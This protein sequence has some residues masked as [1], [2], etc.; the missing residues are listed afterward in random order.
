MQGFGCSKRGQVLGPVAG[1]GVF[2]YGQQCQDCEPVFEGINN[3]GLVSGQYTDAANNSHAF[4]YDTNTSTYT[5]ITVP[6][7]SSSQAWGIN[8]NGQVVVQ[9]FNRDGIETN[10]LY[11]QGG[12][13]EPATWAL[14]IGG[15]GLAGAALRRQRKLAAA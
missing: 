7:A 8:N 1:T 10:Y 13:P 3:S 11:S 15:F 6:G 2:Q 9:G 14:M 4:I 5:D 12:V